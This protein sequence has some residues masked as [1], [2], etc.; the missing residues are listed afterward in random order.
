MPL[1]ICEKCNRKFK[2]APSNIGN[3]NYCSRRCYVLSRYGHAPVTSYFQTA[4]GVMT[5]EQ[6][7]NWLKS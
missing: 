7:E 6:T 4:F 1:V 2:R 5:P 3:H